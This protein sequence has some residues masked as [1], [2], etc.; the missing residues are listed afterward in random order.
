MI[1]KELSGT[2]YGGGSRRCRLE[3]GG[4][5]RRNLGMKRTATAAEDS[6]E[7][8]DG[9]R[10]RMTTTE[11]DIMQVLIAPVDVRTDNSSAATRLGQEATDP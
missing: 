1:I 7:P 4:T 6:P 11:D 8:F 3:V 9:E 5:S 10:R 2:E